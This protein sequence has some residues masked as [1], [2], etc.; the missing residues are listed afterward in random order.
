[1]IPRYSLPE[2]AGLFTDRA[3]FS[4]WLEVEVL[5]VEG[6]AT[7]GVVPAAGAAAVRE[8]APEI[9]DETLAKAL[10]NYRDRWRAR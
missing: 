5:A 8:R 2:M 4:T 6:W 9:T 1:M 3:R 10:A 7:L